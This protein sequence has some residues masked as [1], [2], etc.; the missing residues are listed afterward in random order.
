M[1]NRARP[2]FVVGF[3]IAAL[4]LIACRRDAPSTA[5]ASTTSAS[6][7]EGSSATRAPAYAQ[8]ATALSPEDAA[9]SPSKTGGFDGAAAY[10]YTAKLVSF[11]PRPP[12]SDAIHRTQDYLISQLKSFGCAV[13]EDNFNS[14]T[15][16]G[17]V[18]M[19][20]IIA[21]VHGT[22]DGIILLL[23]HYDTL[24]M[25][26]FVG[27][28]DGG[29]STGLMLEEAKLLCAKHGESNSIWIAFLDG[30]EAQVSW[31]DTDSVYGSRELAAR[32]AVSGDLKHVRAVVLADMI[33][34]KNLHFPRES[35]STKWLTDLV[36]TTAWRLGYDQIFLP[37]E[38]A[39]EDDHQPFL[40]RGV[41]AVDIIDLSDYQNEDYWH[42]PRDTMDKI[43]A[44]NIAIV[45]HVIL[46][47]VRQLQLK[48]N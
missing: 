39:I 18:A 21:K 36:W 43:S 2:L 7:G 17:N 44:R 5:A 35:G 22:E 20:N 29:S 8:S 27:A 9:P 40:R 41:A 32:M 1:R 38:T 16:I 37:S 23:T 19:K 12:A 15:P 46:E 11:G 33:G 42:T 3:A 4:L 25:P 34:Q 31:T 45:G 6:L 14:Q 47:T 26:N 10:D 13:D 48:F 30:E 24:R 28:E